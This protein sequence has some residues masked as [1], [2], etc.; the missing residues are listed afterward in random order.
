MSSHCT[1][2]RARFVM[3][4]ATVS[5]NII[6][7]YVCLRSLSCSPLTP[8]CLVSVHL[9]RNRNIATY[10]AQVITTNNYACVPNTVNILNADD[11]ATAAGSAISLQVNARC[12]GCNANSARYICL[13]AASWRPRPAAS[14]PRPCSAAFMWPR[15]AN[16]QRAPVLILFGVLVR[17]LSDHLVHSLTCR[18]AMVHAAG[19][20]AQASLNAL[21]CHPERARGHWWGVAVARSS[22]TGARLYQSPPLCSRGCTVRQ[23]A[24]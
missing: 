14:H 24:S 19:E 12:F 8:M 15:L 23:P 6:N 17:R 11:S 9:Y 21:V 18:P 1:D 7:H 10:R 16:N 20:C 5:N 13:V 22:V 2:A 3:I 4:G